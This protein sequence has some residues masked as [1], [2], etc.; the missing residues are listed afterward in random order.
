MLSTSNSN[1]WSI[2][3][4]DNAVWS[5]VTEVLFIQMTP[6]FLQNLMVLSSLVNQGLQVYLT[7]V[8]ETNLQIAVCC[9]SHPVAPTAEVITHWADKAHRPLVP[10]DAEGLSKLLKY[11]EYLA[12]GRGFVL[13]SDKLVL[14]FCYS[15]HF[16]RRAWTL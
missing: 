11:K 5:S 4:F 10:R 15:S 8:K 2:V 9:D 16:S 12:R 13:V 7:I 14:S 1:H 3:S 6:N